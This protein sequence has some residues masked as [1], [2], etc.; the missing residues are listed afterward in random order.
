[1]E[2]ESFFPEPP[3]LKTGQKWHIFVSYRSIDRPWVLKLYDAL[4]HLKYEVFVDQF[5]LSAGAPLAGSLGDGVDQSGA[6]VIVWSKNYATS[7]WTADEY[8]A[9]KSRQNSN[10]AFKLGIAKKDTTPTPGLLAGQISTDFSNFPDGPC[11]EGLLRLLLGLSGRPLPP[12]AVQ[13]A[14]EIDAAR[15]KALIE[16]KAAR[17][18]DDPERIIELAKSGDEAWTGSPIC[19]CE[20][21]EALIAAERFDAANEILTGLR[22][23]FPAAVRPRQLEGLAA[24]RRGDWQGAMRILGAM[25][26]EDYRDSETIGMYAATWMV[27]Y[28]ETGA[29][30]YLVKSRDLYREAFETSS[31]SYTGINAAT[32]SLLLGERE[33]ATQLAARVEALFANRPP[34][35]YYEQATL[36]EARLLQGD[37]QQACKHYNAAVLMAPGETGAHKG[38]LEQARDILRSLEAPPQESEAI[39]QVFSHLKLAAKV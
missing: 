5:V 27:R 20:A 9:I 37:Y 15:K 35:D 17:Q 1:M 38:T 28:R 7:N 29:R 32:K 33:T 18:N 23:R 36:A 8:N 11:G 14:T 25:Y 24:R 10:P 13:L 16:I 4:R 30:L 26:A 34:A 39:E 12:G 6:A 31:D 3:E 21:V 2:F 22:K 19:G